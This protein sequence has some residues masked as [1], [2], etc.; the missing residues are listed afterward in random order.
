MGT[1][2]YGRDLEALVVEGGKE[3]IPES[4]IA[5]YVKVTIR[6]ISGDEFRT[7]Y[8]ARPLL[9]TVDF[10]RAFLEGGFSEAAGFQLEA[11]SFQQDAPHIEL[12]ADSVGALALCFRMLATGDLCLLPEDP[13]EVLAVLVEAHRLQL[14]HIVAVAEATLGK[15]LTEQRLPDDIVEALE[16]AAGLFDLPRLA[17]GIGCKLCQC[18]EAA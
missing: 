3:S 4:D 15:A 12:Q 9:L 1:S 14:R 5:D 7:L 8:T 6:Q 13:A 2:S 10:F 11:A 16:I 17:N 18:E